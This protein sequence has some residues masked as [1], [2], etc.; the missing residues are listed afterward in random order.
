[1]M[2]ITLTVSWQIGDPCQLPD[3]RLEYTLSDGSNMNIE[4]LLSLIY[5]GPTGIAIHGRC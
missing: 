2:L 4:S 1:M 3:D 5:R